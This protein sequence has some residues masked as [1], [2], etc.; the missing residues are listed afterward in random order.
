MQKNQYSL[1]PIDRFNSRINKTETCWLWTGTVR[2][3]GYGWFQI[4]GKR[5]AAHRFSYETFKEPIEPGKV[6][7]HTCDNP[8]CVNPEHLVQGTQKENIRDAITKGRWIQGRGLSNYCK[9]GH[10]LEGYNLLYDPK[11]DARKCRECHNARR[12]NN[13]KNNK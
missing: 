12:R 9:N 13:R 7:M 8:L 5:K 11:R 3:K 2:G 10:L 1:N 4:D 6:I